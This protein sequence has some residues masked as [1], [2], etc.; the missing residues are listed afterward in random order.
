MKSVVHVIS[1]GD[2][3]REATL[4]A[5]GQNFQST[6][7]QPIA[8]G[9]GFHCSD[10]ST[11]NGNVDSTVRA[12]QVQALASISSWIAEWTPAKVSRDLS[13]TTDAP[14]PAFRFARNLKG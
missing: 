9:D 11:A 5:D 8:V 10:L 3:W 12:V 2:P 13:E 1:V 6:P 4:S 7:Q 14:V